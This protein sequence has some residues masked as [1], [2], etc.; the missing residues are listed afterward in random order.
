MQQLLLLTDQQQQQ[1]NFIVQKNIENT[2][3]WIHWIHINNNYCGG[4]LSLSFSFSLS[5]SDLRINILIISMKSFNFMPFL[6]EVKKA[7]G[8]FSTTTAHSR[9][10]NIMF[11]VLIHYRIWFEIENGEIW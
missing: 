7:D 9:K 4:R 2:T 5:L 10:W 8:F 11:G 6:R 1:K 3:S